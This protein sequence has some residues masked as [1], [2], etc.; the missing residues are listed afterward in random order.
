MDLLNL[1]T[2]IYGRLGNHGMPFWVMTPY[3]R[4]VRNLANVLLPDYLLQAD[5]RL[6]KKEKGLI[7][8]LTSFPARI[9]NVWQVIECL[10]RQTILPEKIILWLSEEQFP[11]R[12]G[13]P[14]SLIEQLD[15]IFELRFVNGDLRSHKKYYYVLQEFPDETFI[16]CDDDVYYDV[17]MV[18]RLIKT[19]HLFPNCI[20]ANNVAEI[21]YGSDGRLSKYVNWKSDVSFFS[22]KNLLQIGAGGVLYPP[23]SLN[24]L[25]LESEV[26]KRVAPFADDIWLNA[27]ARINHIPIVKAPANN[28]LLPITGKSSSLTSINNGGENLNDVQIKRIR[29]YLVKNDCD[30][31]YDIEYIV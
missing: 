27:M 25:V 13:I 11:E 8:S 20:I 14:T 5:N 7:I 4:F 18:E 6:G 31:V 12:K 19:S 17:R 30:D 3:R 9:N 15:N 29:D 2:T 1:F 21:S 10:K 16:T 22:R 23:K 24:P 28:L 26:F